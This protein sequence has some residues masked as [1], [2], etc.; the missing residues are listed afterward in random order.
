MEKAVIWE[1]GHFWK[2]KV[3]DEMEFLATIKK[4]YLE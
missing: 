3:Y 2:N 1:R 4:F